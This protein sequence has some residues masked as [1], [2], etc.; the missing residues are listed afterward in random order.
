MDAP[1]NIGNSGV[2]IGVGPLFNHRLD[3]A[4]GPSTENF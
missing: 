4:I 1:I 2:P 3:A